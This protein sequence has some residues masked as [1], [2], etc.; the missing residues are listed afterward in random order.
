[1]NGTGHGNGKEA[2]PKTI[3]T[4]SVIIVDSDGRMRAKFG[5]GCVEDGKAPGLVLLSEDGTRTAG[6]V[7]VAEHR[8]MS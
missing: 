2:Y 7:P 3:T 1:M 5:L 4:E 6:R 8:V